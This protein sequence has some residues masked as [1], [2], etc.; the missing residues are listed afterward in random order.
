MPSLITNLE[1][2]KKLTQVSD[3]KLLMP[4][5][6]RKYSEIYLCHRFSS[7]NVAR[8]EY[9]VYEEILSNSSMKPSLV[10]RYLNTKR[11]DLKIKMSLF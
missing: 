10:T 8:L 11:T 4:W 6:I 2:S 9:V 5:K 3:T 1:N 7:D